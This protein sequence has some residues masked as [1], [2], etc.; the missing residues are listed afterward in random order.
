[1]G[2]E[3]YV[4]GEERSVGCGLHGRNA[5]IVRVSSIMPCTPGIRCFTYLSSA[6]L[7]RSGHGAKPEEHNT[8]AAAMARRADHVMSR[9][10]HFT[11]RA[12]LSWAPPMTTYRRPTQRQLHLPW[13][14]S[15]RILAP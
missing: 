15:Y 11:A 13:N 1:M 7:S 9:W 4:T 6:G 2:S 12:K 5:T 10:L 14:P 8:A 3:W